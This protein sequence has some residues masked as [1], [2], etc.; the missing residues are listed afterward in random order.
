MIEKEKEYL[1]I[2][3]SSLYRFVQKVNEKIDAGY[4]PA[5]GIQVIDTETSMIYFQAL[6]KAEVMSFW[7]TP[8]PKLG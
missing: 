6:V 3:S 2:E 5:G 1:V 4:V 8:I 7:N